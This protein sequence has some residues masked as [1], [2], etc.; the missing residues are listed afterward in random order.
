MGFF[1]NLELKRINFTEPFKRYLA[2]N[3]KWKCNL[4]KNLL[5]GI[6][7]LDHK[8]PLCISND[9]S[10]DNLQILCSN[11]HQKK[12]FLEHEFINIS[13]K[14]EKTKS[15]RLCWKCKEVVSIHFF[16]KCKYNSK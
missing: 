9:N 7:E 8:K 5:P 2:A 6:F 12:T 14:F 4:C 13:K 3:Q 1:R 16:H 10:V 11:C 15:K